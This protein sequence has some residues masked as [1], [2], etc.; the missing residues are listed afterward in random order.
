MADNA[1]AISAVILGALVLA[2][3][4]ALAVAGV[5]L[6]RRLRAAQRALGEAGAALAAE[7]ARTR[8]LID[9]LPQRQAE[10]QAAV[11]GL[12]ARAAVLGVLARNASEA[13]AVLR[14]PLRV[15]GR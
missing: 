4:A 10:L 3:L 12:S 13:A 2:G 11:A 6:W 14:S 7:S 9:E 8:R 1:V 15:L 5:M